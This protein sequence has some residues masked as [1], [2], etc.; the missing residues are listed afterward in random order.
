[1]VPHY[2]AAV[3]IDDEEHSKEQANGDWSDD[4]LIIPD[5]VDD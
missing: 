2:D 3:I 5:S 1:M 4:R